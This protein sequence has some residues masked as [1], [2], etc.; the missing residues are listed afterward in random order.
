MAPFNQ[1]GLILQNRISVSLAQSATAKLVIIVGDVVA[2]C[3]LSRY[4][5]VKSCL[6][7]NCPKTLVSRFQ[8]KRKMGLLSEIARATSSFRRSRDFCRVVTLTT[9][10]TSIGNTTTKTIQFC[11]QCQR[12]PMRALLRATRKKRTL[13]AMVRLSITS[14]ARYIH[15]VSQLCID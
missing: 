15:L 1:R 12:A 7:E 4:T 5:M 13:Q 10:T 9:T 14:I 3:V 8:R 11:P 6:A 2:T